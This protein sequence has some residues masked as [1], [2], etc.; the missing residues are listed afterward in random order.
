MGIKG[1]YS[2]RLSYKERLEFDTLE[3]D[4]PQLEARRDELQTEMLAESDHGKMKALGEALGKLTEKIDAA[5]L[6][7]LELSE[8]A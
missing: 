7:W 8:R 3:K 6:R 5:E 1:D 4:L 2:E